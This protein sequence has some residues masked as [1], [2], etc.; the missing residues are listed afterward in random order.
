[1]A[2]SVTQ[3]TRELGIRM[4]LG[5]PRAAVLRL[6]LRQG[7]ILVGIGL[8]V[9]LLVAAFPVAYSRACCTG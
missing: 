5:S 1:M 6:V 9:G 3:R 7:A 2:L 4:A 8:T